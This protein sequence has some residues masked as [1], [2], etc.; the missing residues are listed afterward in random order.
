MRVGPDVILEESDVEI[1]RLEK[2]KAMVGE[3]RGR[4]VLSERALTLDSGWSQPLSEILAVNMDAGNVLHLRTAAC[5]W[6]V[7]PK[8]GSTWKWQNFITP[9]WERA[10]D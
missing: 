1:M 5:I 6:R 7:V 8:R 3:G 4:L 10:R 2:G 9:Y